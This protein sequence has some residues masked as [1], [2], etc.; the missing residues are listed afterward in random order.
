[1]DSFLGAGHSDITSQGL[2]CHPRCY[3]AFPR[4]LGRLRRQFG[5]LSLETMLQRMTDNPARRFGLTKRGRIQEGYLADLV[6]FD[7]DQIIDTATYEDPRQFP[8]G[9][10]L[11]VVNGQL[12]VD[13]GRCTGVLAGQ[14]VP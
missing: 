4:F 13:E 12:A 1:M 3:G 2:L 14:A 5:G 6:V 7:P 8:V 9:I 10:F 11:V